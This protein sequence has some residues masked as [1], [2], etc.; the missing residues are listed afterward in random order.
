[1]RVDRPLRSCVWPSSGQSLA[2]AG[3]AGLYL[4][5][6]KSWSDATAFAP[7]PIVFLARVCCGP[8]Q[9]MWCYQV[10]A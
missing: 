10:A 6:F 5:G 3:D 4:F 8:M 2:A 7:E 1:M 9:S